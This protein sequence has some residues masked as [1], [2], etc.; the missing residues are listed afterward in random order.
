MK[1][2]I[3]RL[4]ILA[5]IS[6]LSLFAFAAPAVA[7]NQIADPLGRPP[8][9]REKSQAKTNK[10][11]PAASATAATGYNF[12]VLYSFG[13]SITDG[14]GPMA[15]L[16][17]DAAG[18]LYGTTFFGG[19]N[20]S[21]TVFKLDSTGQETVLYNFCSITNCTDGAHPAAGLIQDTAGNLYGTTGGGGD[22]DNGTV[23]KLAGCGKRGHRDI[24]SLQRRD[25]VTWVRTLGA[26]AGGSQIVFRAVGH[27]AP[28]AYVA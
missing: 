21:G 7:Q 26:S 28:S 15:S 5:L 25:F 1:T 12:Q 4:F 19:S 24:D 6:S 20:G 27:T 2:S 11:R 17:Q 13:A 14:T 16:I 9:L 22:N 10:A 18:N 3:H 8:E 23:F